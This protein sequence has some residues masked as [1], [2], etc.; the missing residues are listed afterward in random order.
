M[1]V[2]ACGLAACSK[3]PVKKHRAPVA[4]SAPASLPA[5]AAK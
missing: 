3:E 2:G 5:P 1:I 4:V